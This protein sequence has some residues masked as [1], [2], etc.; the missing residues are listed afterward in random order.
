MFCG[1]CGTEIPS[2]Y[3]FC[4][5]CGFP[6]RHSDP[7]GV[8]TTTTAAQDDARATVEPVEAAAP[9]RKA[10]PADSSKLR[11]IG[12]W[13]LLFCIGTAILYPLELLAE[14]ILRPLGLL[15][16]GFLRPL[17]LLHIALT[18]LAICTGVA[19]WRVRPNALGLVK[20]YFI[21][22]VCWAGL[23][24]IV[25]LT[26]QQSTETSYEAMPAATQAV[27]E[28]GVEIIAVVIWWFYFKK[29]KRVKA[30]FGRNL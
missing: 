25:G 10:T 2:N 15:D 18:A 16:I 6:L 13:L 26:A 30:T 4:S 7:V 11:G 12:G 20:A 22:L 24:V 19:L 21:S 23:L 14:A 27:A 17:G 9:T 29:S 28:G 8:T 5:A 3:S 1:K